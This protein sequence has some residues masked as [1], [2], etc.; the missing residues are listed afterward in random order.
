MRFVLSVLLFTIATTPALAQAPD[1]GAV[2]QRECAVCHVNPTGDSRAP[3]R[4]ALRQFFPDAIVTTLTTGAMRAQGEKLSEAERRAVAEFLTDQ[5]AGKGPT[6]ITTGRCA[7]AAPLSDPAKGP[8]WNGWGA[9][10]TNTRFQTKELGGLTAVDVPK[11]TLKWAFGLPDVV[12]A[13]AQPAV[14]GGRL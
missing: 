2:F 6:V 14:A 9:G 4:E 13:R 1:G 11:L 5:S 12:A 10:A 3:T 7:A 8:R